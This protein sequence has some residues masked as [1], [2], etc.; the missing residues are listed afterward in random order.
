M[1][2]TTTTINCYNSNCVNNDN[3]DWMDAGG[4]PSGGGAAVA[5]PQS[6]RRGGAAAAEPAGRRA[7][8][9]GTMAWNALSPVARLIWRCK[10][11]PMPDLATTSE[12]LIGQCKKRAAPDL[13]HHSRT[14]DLAI[15]GKRAPVLALALNTL[16]PIADLIWQPTSTHRIWHCSR[17]RA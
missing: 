8:H 10:K 15:M 12:C 1:K 14:P 9:C 13:A 17:R 5:V 3:N 6:P 11:Y 16:A 7:R 4:Q 2:T